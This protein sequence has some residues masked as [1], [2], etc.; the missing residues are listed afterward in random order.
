[1][2]PAFLLTSLIGAV[3]LGAIRATN[4][5]KSKRRA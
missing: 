5:P 1:M 3:S 2:S 4:G